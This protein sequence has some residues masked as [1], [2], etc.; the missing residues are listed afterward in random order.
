MFSNALQYKQSVSKEKQCPLYKRIIIRSL[1]DVQSCCLE[2]KTAAIRDLHANRTLSLWRQR[3]FI[4]GFRDTWF[5]C[6]SAI[7]PLLSR[8][9]VSVYES[10]HRRSI[11]QPCISECVLMC[12]DIKD[13]P[14]FRSLVR[15]WGWVDVN[16]AS[17]PLSRRLVHALA[18]SFCTVACVCVSIAG[19]RRWL[20]SRL[21]G[22]SGR[23][24]RPTIQKNDF[25]SLSPAALGPACTSAAA[26]TLKTFP[27]NTT[28]RR[29]CVFVLHADPPD[30]IFGFEILTC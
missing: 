16:Q 24:L 22:S 21:N 12:L 23:G 17:E 19:H 13:E 6:V 7:W 11:A 15:P 2:P 18:S 20:T 28:F 4:Q 5:K 1:L 30:V 27:F 9:T 25:F 29:P 26:L 3:I 10:W 14:A 8:L